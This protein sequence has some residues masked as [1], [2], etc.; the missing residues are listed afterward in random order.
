M[1]SRLDHALARR[2]AA[3]TLL[4]FIGSEGHGFSQSFDIVGTRAL[5]MGGAFVAVADDASATWWNPAGLPNSLI[6][7]GIAEGSTGRLRNGGDRP[8]SE[9]TGSEWTSGGVAFAFPVVAASYF[10]TRESRLEPAIAGAPPGRE[11]EGTARVG[12]SLLLHQFGLSLAH[13]LGDAVVLGATV[14]VM[15]GELSTLNP[16]EGHPDDVFDALGEVAGP[17]RTQADVDL[18]VLVRVSRLRVG[19]ATRNLTTPSFRASDGGDWELERQARL[20]VAIVSDA[21]GA[22]RQD[23]VVAIDTDLDRERTPLGD[24][25][26]IAVGGERWFKARRIGVRGGFSASTAGDARPALSGG[27]SV[28]VAS[29]FWVETRVTRGGDDAERGWGISAHL[30]F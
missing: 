13:S 30:M 14:R 12:R 3:L 4:I 9:M 29:G 22:G 20:G 16:A 26:D 25:R 11:N 6:V 19:L 7:D 10:R 15:R 1:I 24:R 2:T 18:G 17:S 21:G 8:I 23:W 5:G 28:A 27:A